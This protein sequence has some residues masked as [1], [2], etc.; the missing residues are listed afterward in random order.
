M[1]K[2]RLQI[3]LLALFFVAFFGLNFTHRANAQHAEL[4]QKIAA[5]C[6]D[7]SE[8][9]DKKY[10][11]ETPEDYGLIRETNF[12][13]EDFFVLK[14]KEKTINNIGNKTKVRLSY[15]FFGYENEEERNYALSF[16]FKNF[17]GEKRITPGRDMRS[18]KGGEPTLILINKN[19]IC[20][21][22]LSCKDFDPDQFRALRKE[23]LN[24]FGTPES[25]LLEL[26]CEGPLQWTKNA[27]DPKDR[28]WRM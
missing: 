20:V 2:P 7:K 10:L 4:K 17:I 22:S 11:N 6:A 14:A 24:Y 28:R 26:G 3:K 27:P 8:K 18:Y 5:F 13:F 16:W 1:Q 12:D 9:Y 21:V 19:N 15:S 23:F 25:I